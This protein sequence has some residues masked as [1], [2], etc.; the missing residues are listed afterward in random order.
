MEISL[1][2]ALQTVSLKQKE[3][4]PKNI[5]NYV[6]ATHDGNNINQINLRLDGLKLHLEAVTSSADTTSTYTK[7]FKLPKDT[8]TDQMSY[9]IDESKHSLVVEAPIRAI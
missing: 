8:D 3:T 2:R 7:Q 1:P 5:I 4:D 9:R 6:D